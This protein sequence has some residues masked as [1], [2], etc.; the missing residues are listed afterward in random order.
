MD[1]TPMPSLTTTPIAGRVPNH[2][3]E[4]IRSQAQQRGLT[5]SDYVRHLITTAITTTCT[6]TPTR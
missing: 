6:D 2:I 5:V 4:E 3:A 1:V